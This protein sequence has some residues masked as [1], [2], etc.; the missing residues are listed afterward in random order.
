MR[1]IQ[2]IITKSFIHADIG[3]IYCNNAVPVIIH[4]VIIEFPPLYINQR[5]A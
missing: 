5:N 2:I 1:R 3:F 4:I